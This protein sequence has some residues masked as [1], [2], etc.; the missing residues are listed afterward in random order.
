MEND[1][2]ESA[3]S[4]DFDTQIK[5]LEIKLNDTNNKLDELK[6]IP[7]IIPKTLEMQCIAI[8][9][10]SSLSISSPPSLPSNHDGM[11]ALSF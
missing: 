7:D 2:Q 5:G 6:K 9:N 10:L 8:S 4:S 3:R 11:N 1:V